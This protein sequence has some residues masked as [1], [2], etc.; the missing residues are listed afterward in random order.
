MSERGGYSSM[1]NRDWTRR[2]AAIFAD[3]VSH[4]ADGTLAMLD[5]EPRH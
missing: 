2:L 4:F 5:A 3:E 1:V